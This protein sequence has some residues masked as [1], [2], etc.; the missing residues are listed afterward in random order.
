MCVKNYIRLSFE[1][2]TRKVKILV[3]LTC[4]MSLGIA[5]LISSFVLYEGTVHSRKECDSVLKYGN[6]NTGYI[7]FKSS[8]RDRAGEVLDSM[9]K[10][11][12]KT[13]FITRDSV[14]LMPL[15]ELQQVQSKLD[16][17]SQKAKET[18]SGSGLDCINMSPSF[19]EMCDMELS[20]GTLPDK[21]NDDEIYIYVGANIDCEIGKEYIQENSFVYDEFGNIIRD[22][23]GEYVTTT[24]RYVVKGKFEKGSRIVSPDILNVEDY[25]DETTVELDD[26]VVLVCNN[27][28]SS[29]VYSRFVCLD[30]LKNANELNEVME[31]YSLQGGVGYGT[32]SH[33]FDNMDERNSSLIKSI[34][35]L[36]FIIMLS[37]IIIQGCSQIADVMINVK[38]YGIY[39][40]NGF[41]KVNIYIIML[42]ETLWKF[43]LSASI[44]II[45]GVLFADYYFDDAKL[46][47]YVMDLATGDV[48]VKALAIAAGVLLMAQMIPMI[49]ISRI[50][51]ATLT[52]ANE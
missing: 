49:F 52:K 3:M 11:G 50:D 19:C 23:N 7:S 12:L 48:I 13:G 16:Y 34:I 47:D 15:S 4:I 10:K 36:V 24:N 28:V 9:G 29:T 20:E 25:I 17:Y 35:R 33:V 14:G 8:G 18:G 37:V 2:L 38:E 1:F 22:E 39:F 5:L 31:E 32:I 21:L 43:L 6:D 44:A 45:A 30:K 40:A 27:P 42:I 51:V 26:L 46:F 41:T